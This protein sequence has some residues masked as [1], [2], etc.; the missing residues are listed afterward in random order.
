MEADIG[1]LCA[2]M[3]LLLQSGSSTFLDDPCIS[4]PLPLPDL[5]GNEHNTQFLRKKYYLEEH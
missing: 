1:F 2:K 4:F 3:V 5:K